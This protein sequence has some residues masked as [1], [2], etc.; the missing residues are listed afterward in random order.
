M[1]FSVVAHSD[2]FDAEGALAE[3]VE[4]CRAELGERSPKAGIVFCDF[5][6]EHDEILEGILRVWPDLELIGCTT[7]GEI[8]SILGYREDSIA[9]VLMGSDTIEF[10]VGMGKEA[11]KDIPSACRAAIESAASK[12]DLTPTICITLP[13]SM[14][15]SALQIVNSLTQLLGPSVPVVGGTAGDGHRLISTRQ[16]CGREVSSDSVPVLLL[17]GPLVYSVGLSSGWEPVGE[18]GVVTRSEGTV[19]R[20]IDGE[21]ALEFYRRFLGKT[22][23]PTPE[24][25]LAILDE[26]GGVECLRASGG[27][28]DPASG[29]HYVLRRDTRRGDGADHTC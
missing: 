18:P 2:D 12:S 22:A 15:T 21:P 11:S 19:V 25:P 1:F 20:E 14:T 4:Q 28:F 6:L 29:G 8:S 17:S 27:I 9:L 26:K 13:E 24:F 5:D 10:S 23:E 7:D 3:I 16:F